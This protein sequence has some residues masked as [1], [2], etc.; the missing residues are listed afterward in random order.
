V[1]CPIPQ[2]ACT[3][4]PVFGHASA[5]AFSSTQGF[6]N[7]VI[8]YDARP[9]CQDYGPIFMADNMTVTPAPP[10]ILLTNPA[11]LTNGVFQFGFTNTPGASFSV[12]GAANLSLPFSNWTVLGGVTETAPGQYQFSDAQATNGPQRFYRVRSP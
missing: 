7:V 3:W 11:K 9:A 2:R 12:F 10:A 6:D 1:S 4:N 8:H 5:Q